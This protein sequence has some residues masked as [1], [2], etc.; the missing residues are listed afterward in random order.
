M[1]LDPT[2][3]KLSQ[4]HWG[5]PQLP[6][7]VHAV[8]QTGSPGTLQGSIEE[9][10]RQPPQWLS[11]ANDWLIN[12]HD[13]VDLVKS[14]SEGVPGASEFGMYKLVPFS[15]MAPGSRSNYYHLLNHKDEIVAELRGV[16]MDKNNHIHVGHILSRKPSSQEPGL[17]TSLNWRTWSLSNEDKVGLGHALLREFPESQT[18]GDFR[19]TGAR[20]RYPMNDPRRTQTIPYRHFLD[21]KAVKSEAEN[22]PHFPEMESDIA[23]IV[24]QISPQMPRVQNLSDDQLIREAQ[25]RVL[26]NDELRRYLDIIARR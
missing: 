18:I 12:H 24:K 13:L 21:E 2:L 15:R 25:E 14:F 20:S 6:G 11:G 3:E 9:S 17:A 7:D 23:G 22:L 8:P 5:P 19:A 26:S 4:Q 1:P 16:F 10:G